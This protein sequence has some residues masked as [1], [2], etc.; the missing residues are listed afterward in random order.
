MKVI[1]SSLIRAA[2]A[3]IVGILLIQYREATMA[4]LIRCIGILFFMSGL[5]SCIVYYVES[6]RVKDAPVQVDANGKEIKVRKPFFPIVGLGSI[7]LGLFLALMPQTFIIY[8]MYLLGAILIL[9]AV[10]QFFSLAQA[11]QFS[12]VPIIHWVFPCI[13]FVIAVLIIRKPLEAGSLPLL[14]TGWC[15]IFYG[16][17]EALNSFQIH[18]MR[19]AFEQ[20]MLQ[21]EDAQIIEE[22]DAEPVNEN[23]QSH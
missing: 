10:N 23:E 22:A 14:A 19:K 4:W 6:K 17:I 5:I 13:T 11:R 9:G 3:V 20:S 12:S 7:I 16:I 8:A 2:I 21:I 15:F 1:Q 18:R